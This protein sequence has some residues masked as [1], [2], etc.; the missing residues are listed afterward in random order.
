MLGAILAFP[1]CLND[2]IAITG[3]DYFYR[4][5]H[6]KIFRTMMEH[7][8]RGD[9][10]DVLTLSDS[11]KAKNELDSVGGAAYLASCHDS[12]PTAV[13]VGH[14][15]RIVKRSFQQRQLV[16]LFTECTERLYR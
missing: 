15:A 2:V 10:I 4:D 9:P 11:L 6:A 16:R 8:E 3:P 5:A 7:A 13:N 1:D 12:V 14:Y